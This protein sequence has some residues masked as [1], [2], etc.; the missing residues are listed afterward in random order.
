MRREIAGQNVYMDGKV[1][2]QEKDPM[3]HIV[4]RLPSPVVR[5]LFALSAAGLL[6]GGYLLAR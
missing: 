6:V 4:R 1:G 3:L 5:T 2:H